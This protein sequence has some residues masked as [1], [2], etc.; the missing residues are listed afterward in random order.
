MM[1]RIVVTLDC[2]TCAPQD[3]V[4]L[5]RARRYHRSELSLRTNEV[6]GVRFS[7]T[8]ADF[9]KCSKCKPADLLDV[10]GARR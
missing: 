6:K 4:E 7:E 5:G 9:A 10:E 3:E 8:L 1:L 2:D